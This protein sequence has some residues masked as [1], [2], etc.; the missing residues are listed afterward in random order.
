MSLPLAFGASSTRSH[1]DDAARPVPRE[2][3]WMKMHESFVER[4]KAGDVD[5]LFLGDS[6]TK[7]WEND[8][9]WKRY[10][11]PRRAAH[12]GIGGDRTEH[13]LW[14]VENGELNGIQPKV[15]VLLIGTNNTPANSASEIADGIRAIVATIRH[16]LPNSKILLLGIFPKGESPNAHRDKIEDVNREIAKLHDGKA[17]TYLDI[18]NRFVSDDGTISR[19]VMP[20]SLHLSRAGYRIW[21][22]A[23]EPTLWSLLE[24]ETVNPKAASD[25]R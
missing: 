16:D 5:L 9:V 15:V 8:S 1:A 25:R 18:G 20:D 7:A 23:M 10:Y 24:E 13:L 12:F 6:L 2:G 19:E 3:A 17:I 4:A 21:A 11:G 14:R 22:D